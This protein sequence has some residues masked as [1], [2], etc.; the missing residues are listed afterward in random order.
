MVD[1]RKKELGKKA[2]LLPDPNPPPKNIK[3]IATGVVSQGS[4]VP[5]IEAGS[6]DV[7]SAQYDISPKNSQ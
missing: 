7:K 2:N 1:L 3:E 5:N 4:D 6:Q